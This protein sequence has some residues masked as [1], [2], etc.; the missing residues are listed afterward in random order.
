MCSVIAIDNLI[1]CTHLYNSFKIDKAIQVYKITCQDV[2]S[3]NQ[4][5]PVRADEHCHCLST[6]NQISWQ[7]GS[8]HLEMYAQ[9]QSE[10]TFQIVPR[11]QSGRGFITKTSQVSCV[12]ECCSSR[13]PCI[14][15]DL[16]WAS[17]KG[18][19]K[20]KVLTDSQKTVNQITNVSSWDLD[21]FNLLLSWRILFYFLGV[22]LL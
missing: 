12:F 22:F 15:L 5:S 6:S 8:E 14:R 20:I 13:S 7:E 2:K 1:T 3:L 18:I 19:R 9:A 10:V 16:S 11:L 4:M 21:T 17:S